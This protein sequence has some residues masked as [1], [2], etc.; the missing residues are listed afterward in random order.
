[1]TFLWNFYLAVMIIAM[2]LG[3]F[4]IVFKIINMISDGYSSVT[5]MFAACFMFCIFAAFP[6]YL[7]HIGKFSE[8]FIKAW[9]F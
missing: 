7:F 2:L 4:R 5:E 9:P 6:L 1:M 3:C 8:I